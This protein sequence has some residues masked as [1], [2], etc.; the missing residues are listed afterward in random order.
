MCACERARTCIDLIS[1][2]FDAEVLHIRI[3]SAPNQDQHSV[4]HQRRRRR[5]VFLRERNE[6]SRRIRWRGGQG[7]KERGGK[8]GAW[9]G[10]MLLVFARCVAQNTIAFPYIGRIS[11]YW[12]VLG[13]RTLFFFLLPLPTFLPR[14]FHFYLLTSFLSTVDPSIAFTLYL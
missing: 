3:P 14:F 12:G 9:V 13:A 4:R 5:D 8:Y 10:K 6:C 7:E 1:V 11:V 2:V